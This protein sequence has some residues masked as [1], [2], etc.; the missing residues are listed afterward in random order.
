MLGYKL[1]KLE[2][3]RQQIDCCCLFTH[4]EMK[5]WRK[6][7][8]F[9]GSGSAWTPSRRALQNLIKKNSNENVKSNETPFKSIVRGRKMEKKERQR[10]GREGLLHISRCLT[11]YFASGT[12][13]SSL[14]TLP[15]LTLFLPL[16]YSRLLNCEIR[17]MRPC[18]TAIP[19]STDDVRNR[20]LQNKRNSRSKKITP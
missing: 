1:S 13:L 12:D 20:N 5:F 4:I 19:G 9:W 2:R 11:H 17:L 10:V 14:R 16:H 15:S 3:K 6:Q 7:N 18:V 8:V